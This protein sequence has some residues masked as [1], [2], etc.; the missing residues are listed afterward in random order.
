MSFSDFPCPL[1]DYWRYPPQ[2]S[3]SRQIPYVPPPQY[4]PAFRRPI[5]RPAAASRRG[6]DAP[7][8]KT[9]WKTYLSQRLRTPAV[10]TTSIADRQW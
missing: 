4:L 3:L 6:S 7:G 8:I 1:P 10:L 5:H 9:D 2:P